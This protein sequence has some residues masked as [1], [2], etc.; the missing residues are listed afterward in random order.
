M[1]SVPQDSR[2]FTEFRSRAQRAEPADEHL[3][4]GS[5]GAGPGDS[6]LD[7]ASSERELDSVVVE[8]Q[9]LPGDV[10][11]GVDR[12]RGVRAAGADQRGLDEGDRSARRAEDHWWPG[13]GRQDLQAEAACSCGWMSSSSTETTRETPRSS[14]VTP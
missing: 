14:M 9:P 3:V 13:D 11:L 6:Q 10:A 7:A 12:L 1:A 4:R 8:L 5:P 2:R